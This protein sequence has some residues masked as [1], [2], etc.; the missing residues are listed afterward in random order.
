MIKYWLKLGQV[1]PAPLCIMHCDADHD[2]LVT[3]GEMASGN[4]DFLC[5]FSEYMSK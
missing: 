4:F 1:F 3:L 2:V 5:S